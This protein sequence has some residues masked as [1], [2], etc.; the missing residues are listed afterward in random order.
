MFGRFVFVNVLSGCSLGVWATQKLIIIVAG[1]FGTI[2]VDL[3]SGHF[4]EGDGV[5]RDTDVFELK[6]AHD[7]L[8]TTF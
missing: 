2:V 5:Q 1:V 3:V 8:R 6:L 7:F 4:F